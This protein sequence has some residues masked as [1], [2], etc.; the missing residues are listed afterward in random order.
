M[1][2]GKIR[3]LLGLDESH[4]FNFETDDREELAGDA[5]G[6]L[7]MKKYYFGKAWNGLDL[8]KQDEIIERLLDEANPE[9]LKAVALEDW[10][11]SEDQAQALADLSDADLEPGTARFS[12][13]ALYELIP[14]LSEQRISLTEAVAQVRGGYSN[15]RP[16]A[17]L[18]EP[19]LKYYG[20]II[21]DSV[22]PQPHA[23]VEEERVY[24]RISD[25]TV[26]IGLN[27]LRKLINEIIAD[28]G[29][30]DEMIV[31]ISRDLKM[32][33]DAKRSLARTQK[34]DRDLSAEAAEYIK[35]YG[36]A[37]NDGNILRYKLWKELNPS[38]IAGRNSPYS[39]RNI[40][41]LQ[42][43][44]DQI[45]IGHI[46]PLS[47]T[48]DDSYNNKTLCFADER[49]MKGNFSPHEACL[50][51]V[52]P[53]DHEEMLSRASCLPQ[54]KRFRFEADA[55]EHWVD[56]AGSSIVRQLTDT[57]YLSKAVRLYLESLYPDDGKIHVRA[58]PGHLTAEIRAQWRL[59]SILSV[60]GSNE[61]NRNDYRR[62]AI[63]A[64]VIGCTDQTLLQRA[65]ATA[66]HLQELEFA[67]PI[68][69]A[70]EFRGRVIDRVDPVIVSH[71]PD[72][73]CQGAM[74]E[75]TNY[76]IIENRDKYEAANNY[77]LVCRKPFISLFA[78]L[79]PEKA[80][81]K[82]AEI[83]DAQ[84]RNLLINLL[85]RASSKEDVA[86]IVEAFANQNGIRKI[87][88]LK[89]E[90]TVIPI[91]HPSSGKRF[92]KGVL[93][94][95]VN[96]IGF[97]Q[98]PSGEIKALGRSIFEVNQVK[99]D[100]NKLKPHPAAKLKMILYKKDMLRVVK[101]GQL[102]TCTVVSISPV[103]GTLRL[104]PHNL[105]RSEEFQ[106]SFGQLRNYQVRKI[107][108]TALGKFHDPG[109]MF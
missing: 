18:A 59:N 81:D 78:D 44:S 101:S 102:L 58:I 74:H 35:A 25:P 97:W 27:Q 56:R 94:G 19:E 36:L 31:E 46:L 90:A 87:R 53:F 48:L 4:N 32:S 28:R 72:H 62:H 50:N 33:R 34:A 51:N 47:R 61:E 39:G 7:M 64:V 82:A 103:V 88:L 21:A 45:A 55:M 68:G 100:L 108:M 89:K 77:N 57:Q 85:E 6:A 5:T 17:R 73:G 43:F 12:T 106:V 3:K 86:R 9:T 15:K 98:M 24:G 42:L 107:S 92:K 37:M 65:A 52:W 70:G 76:G 1:G 22:A 91:E 60:D 23:A 96:H 83:R 13:R 80:I 20:E 69:T 40:S 54:R 30:P 105:A 93:P 10:G 16:H 71:R 84:L 99:G 49:R 109:P 79:D 67:S 29:P 66:A 104:R 63:D 26:H 14:L 2:F 41:I 75:A 38:D 95:K 11:L 8:R